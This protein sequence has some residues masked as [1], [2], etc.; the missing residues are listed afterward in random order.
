MLA[1]RPS[2]AVPGALFLCSAALLVAACGQSGDTAASGTTGA[3][4]SG[5]HTTSSTGTG[6]GGGGGEGG[7]GGTD[8]GPGPN[9]LAILDW[10]TH[11]FFD[12]VHDN[13]NNPSETVL[14]TAQ[15]TL[16]R[17]TIGGVI[18]ALA[19]D[20]AVLQEVEKKGILD[21][22]N[23]TE[24]DGAYVQTIL[25]DANDPR[26]ID[27]GVLTKFKP[28][29][30]ITHQS[31]HFLKVGTTMP[32]YNYT[33]DC[34]ELHFKAGGQNVILLGVHFKSKSPTDDPDKRL[35]EAQHTRV[36]ADDL[37]KLDPSARILILGDFNDTPGSPA[38]LAITGAAP[39]AYADSA[40]AVP[41]AYSYTFMKMHELIDHQMANPA[42]AASLDPKSVVIKHG[43]GVDD[44]SPAASD[45]APILG[46]YH[47]P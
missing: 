25:I 39:D 45:H 27:V 32:L 8:P 18:K 34:L 5:A 1:A 10:N 13:P 26:G 20:I 12:D 38:L 9:M 43:T 36:I 47:F 19:P 35:A 29:S 22:L 31:D 46:T 42:M 4:T 3:N 40:A 30:V 11:D 33:R 2:I 16:K 14:T 37:R 15:Y 7:A 17:K 44:N 28:S 41:M 23:K 21:D 24:L 6:S